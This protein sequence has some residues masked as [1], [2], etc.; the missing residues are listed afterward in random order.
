MSNN[1]FVYVRIVVAHTCES[2]L[3]QFHRHGEAH[4]VRT[5]HALPRGELVRQATLLQQS[6]YRSLCLVTHQVTQIPRRL[7]T[8]QR[9]CLPHGKPHAQR[10]DVPHQYHAETLPQTAT[11]LRG[12]CS[13]GIPRK[14]R[15][16][17][18][19][20]TDH[21]VEVTLD[22][23]FKL[24]Q[25]LTIDHRQ[26]HHTRRILP[27]VEIQQHLP[28]V[29]SLLRRTVAQRLQI[30]RTKL[31]I[32]MLRTTHRLQ[33]HRRPPRV[34]LQILR[35]LA[36][37]RTNLAIRRAR[38]KQRTHEK[39]RKTLQRILQVFRRH[40]QTVICRLRVR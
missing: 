25:T 9:V 7:T 40:L 28:H 14:Y 24:C 16:T 21:T 19:L 6:Q 2:R 3:R 37:H 38:V 31:Q 1:L 10:V 27:T 26:R 39:L 29:E 12:R 17:S 23:R 20:P 4:K 32:R 5:R 36:V 11:T 8:V 18:T 22:H 35:V 13:E 33:Q 34:A 15:R 30:P